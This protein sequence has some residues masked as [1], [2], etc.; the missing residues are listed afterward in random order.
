VKCASQLSG[1]SVLT[2]KMSHP[3]EVVNFLSKLSGHAKVPFGHQPKILDL[4][5][6][7]CVLFHSLPN[8]S[9][10]QSNLCF[11]YLINILDV[12]CSHPFP[13][14]IFLKKIY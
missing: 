12:T 2:P 11:K 7:L 3:H 1:Q 13:I 6:F 14:S 4:K 9:L 5:N 10:N 8:Y